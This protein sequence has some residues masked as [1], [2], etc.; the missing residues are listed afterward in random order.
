MK[1]LSYYLGLKYSIDIIP[2]PEKLGGGYRAVIP[3]LG[4][5]AF[6]GDGETPGEA[7]E[8][9]NEIK[10]ALF[11]Q[12][13]EEGVRIPEPKE[14]YSGRFLVRIPRELHERLTRAARRNGASLNSY[15]AYILSSKVTSEE[16][17][18]KLEGS[19]ENIACKFD[20]MEEMQREFYSSFH[21]VGLPKS[22]DIIPDTYADAA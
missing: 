2:I 18:K 1:N 7:L 13:V 14:E 21:I 6:V 5:L 4:E 22:D 9:L 11:E 8:S 12:Y 20:N 17:V 16:I 19:I 3:E 15:V 10:E